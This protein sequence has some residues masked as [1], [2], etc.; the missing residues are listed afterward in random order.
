MLGGL[1]FS[2]LQ[3]CVQRGTPA[4]KM[5]PPLGAVGMKTVGLSRRSQ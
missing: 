5:R 2:G 4:L 1:F 3:N